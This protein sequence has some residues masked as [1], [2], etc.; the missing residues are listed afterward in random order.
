MRTIPT[1]AAAA[2][3][4]ALA[5]CG[6]SDK[7][8]YCSDRGNLEQ[9]VKDLEKIKV[10]QS[11]G[12]QKLKSQLQKVRSSASATVTSAKDDFPSETSQIDSSISSLKTTVEALPSSP[13]APEL[14]AVAAN[15]KAV[16]TAVQG[17]AEAS[18]SKCE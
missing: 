8:G 2:V 5:G 11:G 13:K 6:G 18:A 7:P 3:V 17:F 1:V 14:A 9:S 16:V 12:V 4:A 15:A 10:L